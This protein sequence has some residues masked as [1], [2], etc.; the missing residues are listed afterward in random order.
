MPWLQTV[1]DTVSDAVATNG[2]KVVRRVDANK[3]PVKDYSLRSLPFR[4]RHL[5][6]KAL[7]EIGQIEEVPGT[8]CSPCSAT[9]T[10]TSPR[11]RC[12]DSFRST[13][14]SSAKRSW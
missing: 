13:S 7:D 12:G 3:R 14:T 11:S 4:M 5:R 1:V 8:R 10:T 2:W 9:R 6:M